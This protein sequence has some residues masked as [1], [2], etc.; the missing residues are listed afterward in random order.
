MKLSFPEI[1]DSV[2]P[3]GFTTNLTG[4]H[5]ARSMM[6]NE[7]TILC[8][9]LPLDA[10]VEKYKSAIINDNILGKPTFSSR[11]E[12]FR[13]LIRLYTLNHSLALFRV[14]RKFA[15][16]DPLSLPLLALVCTFCRDPQLRYS[17]GL[18]DSLHVGEVLSRERMLA[19]LEAG[20]PG[21]YSSIMKNSLAKNVNA[22]WTYAG[23]LKGKAIKKRTFPNEQFA[24][25]IYAMLSGYLLGLRGEILV[26]SV[27]S[28]LVSQ[29]HSTI[30][31]H[32]SAASARGLLRYRSGGGILEI[33]FMPMLTPE[34]RE[35]L[36]GT[37]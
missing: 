28:R 9:M 1:N 19:Y 13:Q 16:T 2:T 32:L 12:S 20:F 7:I 25:S 22:T 24:A 26:K 23:H 3:F 36:H 14:F 18:I 5:T 21:R 6:L 37:N 17:F 33:D 31:S 10:M 29:D 34:E 30:L 15:E 27:F 8:K 35:L 4:G 11:Q